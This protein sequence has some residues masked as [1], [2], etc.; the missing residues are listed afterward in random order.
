MRTASASDGRVSISRRITD[1]ADNEKFYT[2]ATH[3]LRGWQAFAGEYGSGGNLGIARR[4]FMPRLLV[5]GHGVDSN[6]ENR[7]CASLE[8]KACQHL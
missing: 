1:A 8:E 7:K 3:L 4:T 2:S 6:N 5:T